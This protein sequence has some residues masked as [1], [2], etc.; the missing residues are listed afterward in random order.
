[1]AGESNYRE[2]MVQVEKFYTSNYM[3]IPKIVMRGSQI[4][5]QINPDPK[6]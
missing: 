1:M 4:T 5:P 3:T 6:R 2:Y